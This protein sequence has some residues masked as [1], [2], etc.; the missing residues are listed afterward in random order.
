VT[1]VNPKLKTQNSKP[2]SSAATIVAY[3]RAHRNS[4]DAEGAR[5]Y[6]IDPRCELLGLRAAMLRDLARQHRRDHALALA[7]WAQPIHEARGLAALVD[8]PKQITR[9]QMEAWARDFDSWAIVDACCTQLFN[10][11]PFAIDKVRVWSHRRAEYVKRGAFSLMAGLA[12][13]SKQLPDEVFLDFLPII[14]RE[15]TDERNFVKKAVNWAL[16]QIG[17]RNAPLRRAALATAQEILALDTPAARWIA[18]DA[19]RELKNR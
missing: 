9:G 16:R 17:K 12:V 8:D 6:G 11:T 4:R 7:L 14:A 18:R 13:H 2:S 10:H 5:R 1:S 3:L 19:I 15:A